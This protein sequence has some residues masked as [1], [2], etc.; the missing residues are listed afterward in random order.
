MGAEQAKHPTPLPPSPLEHDAVSTFPGTRPGTREVPVTGPGTRGAPGGYPG[1]RPDTQPGTRPDTPGT[2]VVGR[3]PTTGGKKSERAACR[4][5]FSPREGGPPPARQ[6]EKMKKRAACR[7]TFS[8]ARQGGRPPCQTAATPGGATTDGHGG[9]RWVW[10]RHRHHTRSAPF[11]YTVVSGVW[12]VPLSCE[13]LSDEEVQ[14]LSATFVL[15]LP[16]GER[17]GLPRVPTRALR[18]DLHATPHRGPFSR[19][20][21]PRFMAASSGQAL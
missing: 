12:A 11:G 9:T 20:V 5:S 6:G 15:D 1:T 4:S 8:L 16:R 13:L 10:T 3:P 17:H 14:R 7:S 19:G 2:R 21:S 18:Q